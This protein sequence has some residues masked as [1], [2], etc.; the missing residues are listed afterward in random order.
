LQT[1]HLIV[2]SE[3]IIELEIDLQRS[4]RQSSPTR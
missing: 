4:E 3:G 2:V 1:V